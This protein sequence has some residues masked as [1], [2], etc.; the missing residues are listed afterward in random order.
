MNL[1][2]RCNQSSQKGAVSLFIVIFTALL[3]TTITVSFM[4]LMTKDQQQATYGD[5]SE[6]AYDSAIAG[7]EDAK[8]ALLLEQECLGQN[9][10]R[11]N[12]I[13]AAIASGQCNTLD[14][15]FGTGSTTETKIKQSIDDEKL[16]QAYTC[17]K[18]NKDTATFLGALNSGVNPTLVPLRGKD[19]FNRVIISWNLSKSGETVNLPAPGSKSL[20]PVGTDW[21]ESR[22]SLLR[23]QLING[24]GNFRLSD[25]DKSGFSNTLFLYPSPTGLTTAD[26]VVDN[27]RSPSG[28]SEPQLISCASSVPSGSYACTVTVNI[29]PAISAGSQTAFLSI[30]ALYNATDFKVE[31]LNGNVPVMFDGVQ[32]EVDSTGRANDLFR[33]VTSRIEL[34]DTF[35]YPL[36]AIETSGNLCKNFSVTT[37]P[38]DYKN[39]C[40]P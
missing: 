34:N 18:I 16:E 8:R 39:R 11:C 4:Q 3:M 20:P 26:F 2:Q 24:K 33:R 12:D 9:T 28:G 36:A 29:A 6:S 21:P 14:V 23:T 40:T 1:L 31:L 5:L 10:A 17:V 13:R 22:P 35:N 25:F 27:R 37:E 19:S 7:V 30:A 32:P 38:T 15:I